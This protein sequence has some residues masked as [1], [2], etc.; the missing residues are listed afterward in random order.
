[1]YGVKITVESIRGAQPCGAGIK[2][3]DTWT[4]NAKNGNLVMEDFK[5]C[6]PEL[7]SS[8]LSHC[9]VMALDGKM[10]WEIEGK[11]TSCCPDPNSLVVVSMERI[12]ELIE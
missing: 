3:G 6:C 10:D 9:M 12:P 8:I 1:M 5:G 4:I 11:S 2:I 7:L